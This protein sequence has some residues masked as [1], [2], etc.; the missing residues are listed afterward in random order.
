[1]SSEHSIF[2]PI[3]TEPI[4]ITVP[5]QGT[6]KQFEIQ[7]EMTGYTY[8]IKAIVNE[9][10]VFFEP[11]EEKQYRAVVPYEN[12]EAGKKLDAGLLQAIAE[13]LVKELS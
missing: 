10:T 9:V 6:E 13:T 1:M 4:V 11:D 12:A 2:T 3:M 5:Y 8:R 7:L